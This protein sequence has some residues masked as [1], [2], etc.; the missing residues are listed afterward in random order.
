MTKYIPLYEEFIYEFNLTQRKG[1]ADRAIAFVEK[2]IAKLKSTPG[3]AGHNDKKLAFLEKKLKG[4]HIRKSK[5]S[6]LQRGAA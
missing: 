3:P 5:L 6:G 1:L 4:L 2:Q